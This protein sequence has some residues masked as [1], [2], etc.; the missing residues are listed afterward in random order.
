MI[1]ESINIFE[2]EM[3][4]MGQRLNFQASFKGSPSENKKE[5]GVIW[6]Y[7]IT[8]LLGWTPEEALKNLNNEI[9]D[10]LL[11]NKTFQGIDFDREH[12]YIADYRFILQ[13][14]FPDRIRYDMYTETIAEYEKFAKLGRWAS[15]TTPYKQPKRFFTD[16]DGIRRA[17][18]CLR[19]ILDVYMGE[20]NNEEKYKFF[21]DTTKASRWLKSKGL[22]RPNEYLFDG[23]LD[24]FHSANKD[25]DGLIFA[26]WLAKKAF[27]KK[28][29][30]EKEV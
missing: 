8:E 6:R 9:V 10:A 26:S 14:A 2:Y 4:L 29:K 23:P 7:A 22:E 24:Y 20:L 12:S 16:A 30:K 1:T 25:K 17:N 28:K 18:W 13:Y 15:D 3:L 19:H 11:L 21:A 27:D 5:V